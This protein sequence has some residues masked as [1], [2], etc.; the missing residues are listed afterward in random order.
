MI[1]YVD[2]MLIVDSDKAEIKKLMRSLHEKNSM[3]E[4]G[5][6]RH[7][8]GMQIEYVARRSVRGSVRVKHDKWVVVYV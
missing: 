2:D 4:L 3:K 5:E 1:L 7:I 6:A 8:L